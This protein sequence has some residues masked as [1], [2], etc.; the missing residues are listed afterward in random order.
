MTGE[1]WR[2]CRQIT[3]VL[4]RD[5]ARTDAELAVMLHAPVSDV[6]RAVAILYRQHK[7]DRCWNYVVLLPPAIGQEAR[8]A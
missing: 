2:L 8:A 7:I 3:S 5:V 4:G 6:R 1:P